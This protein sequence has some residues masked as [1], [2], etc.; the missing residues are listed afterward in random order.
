[1]CL[2]VPA[3][4]R[5]VPPTDTL[6]PSDPDTV[7]RTQESADTPD[8]VPTDSPITDSSD[9]TQREPDERDAMTLYRRAQALMSEGKHDEG[10][11]TA[12]S[13]M[14]QF[15]ADENDLAWLLLESIDVDGKRVDVH[16]NMSPQERN[17][18]DEGIVRPLSFR[19]WST[20]D[21][22][23]L[24]QVIDFEISRFGGQSLTAAIGETTESGHANYGILELDTPYVE[25]RQKVLDLVAR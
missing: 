4:S 17:Y 1:M 15:I 8:L 20:G 6:A 7:A 16:L 2:F 13:A 19:I 18:P 10:Y 24:L 14:Q 9:E 23:E 11:E 22:P 21:D 3:C 5:Q 12:K 25:I